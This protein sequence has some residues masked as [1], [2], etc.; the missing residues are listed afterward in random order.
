MPTTA[1]ILTTLFSAALLCASPLVARPVLADPPGDVIRTILESHRDAT[2]TL[3]V[4]VRTNAGSGSS[5]D[6]ELEIPGLIIDG[7][8]LVVTTNTAIDPMSTLAGMSGMSEGMDRIT[9]K[10]VNAR[11]LNGEGEE[12]PMKVVLRDSDRNIAFLRPITAPKQAMP[13]VDLK[14]AH[15][16]RIGDLVFFMSR[17]GPVANR[18]P[19]VNLNR[20]IS[21][22]ERPRIFYVPDVTATAL[23]GNAAFSETGEPLGIVT[24]RVNPSGKRRSFFSSNDSMIAVILPGDDIMEAAAQAPQVKDVKD[25]PLPPAPN[26]PAPAKPGTKPA[27]KPAPKAGA[28]KP[29]K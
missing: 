21:V 22:V 7:S 29:G 19:Q 11:L 12:I 20:V 14:K 27:P 5:E 25:T 16:A 4:V 15:Q 17:M 1:R 23:L 13:F 26:K 24:L 8:G 2:I 6:T 10:V 9:T 3:V 18:A 28:K